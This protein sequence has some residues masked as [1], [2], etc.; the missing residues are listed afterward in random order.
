MSALR[1]SFLVSTCIILAASTSGAVGAAPKT[2]QGS[3]P[4]DQAAQ[5][6]QG[7]PQG[8]A[9]QRG[10]TSK[11]AERRRR[12]DNLFA[13]LKLVDDESAADHIVNR[14]WMT[15]FQSGNRKVNDM[16]SLAVIYTNEQE[17]AAALK[18]LNKVVARAPKY[19]E[20]WNRR[21]T[22]YFLMGD[23][24]RSLVDIKKTLALEPRHFGALAGRGLIYNARGQY[25]KALA[26]FEQALKLNPFLTEQ[27][28]IIPLLRQK[29]GIQKI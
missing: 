23:Y 27:R 17:F 9:A 16:V 1:R 7:A 20:G 28:R 3:A 15:W 21:A 24:D 29:L 12:L 14:I 18:V 8:Q 6:N 19:A 4:H 22:L 10:K 2:A 25:K 11:A 5:R 13:A 26:A